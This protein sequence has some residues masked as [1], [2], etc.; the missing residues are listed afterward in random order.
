MVPL[1]LVAAIVLILVLFSVAFAWFVKRSLYLQDERPIA[2]AAL[3]VA[4]FPTTVKKVFL[5][6]GRRLS[7]TPDYS[8]IRATP[9]QH[10][11]SELSPV[12]SRLAGVGEG[13]LVHRGPGTPQRGWRVI[14]GVL[15]IHGTLQTAA[16]LLSP[17]LEI[18]HYWP[19]VEDA[20]IDADYDAPLRKM[21]HGLSVLADGSVIYSFDNGASLHR[22]DRCGLTMW[23]I[24]GKYNHTVTLD[25][26]EQ[27][28]WAL[29]IDERA[30]AAR[31]S[32]DVA[33]DTKI[34]QVA[35]ADG[36]ILKEISVAAIIAANPNIDLLEL[37]RLNQGDEPLNARRTLGRWMTD[38]IHLNDVD[39]LPRLLAD[40][41]P[42]FAA[43]DLLVSA[44]E[45]NLIFV[46]D[47]A[48]LA[49]KWWRMGATIRQHDPDWSANGRI[50][51][52]NNRMTREYSEIT[53]IDPATFATT[54]PVD[55]RNLDL[56]SRRRG[57]HQPLPGGGWLI[58]ST[59]QG[60]V[61]ELSQNGDVALEFYNRM[62]GGDQMFTILSSATFLPE[63]SVKPGAFRCGEN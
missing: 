21:P 25:D 55:G 62:G 40:R 52:F 22:K 33:K 29:R 2:L 1:W 59:E 26:S 32:G 60:R 18:V 53:E 41:F 54:L 7:N 43:G 23:A 17:D 36:R 10:L 51:A 46:M 11:P 49:V 39:P 56:Y 8:V 30:D 27:S 42:M 6:I 20:A 50:S 13:L 9:P 38:P 58:T 16:V 14:A 4:S 5:E 47:P 63:D 12:K 31:Y 57:S 19:L 35:T 15:R 34:V 3:E 48:S 61:I 37:R 28:V 44:R 24:P 45:V